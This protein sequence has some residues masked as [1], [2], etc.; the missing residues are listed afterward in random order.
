MADIVRKIIIKLGGSIITKKESSP[1]KANMPALYR[2][3]REIKKVWNPKEDRLI[4][5]HGAGCFGHIPAHE[6]GLTDSQYHERKKKG[7]LIIYQNMLQLNGFVC[8][9]FWKYE[10][11]VVSFPP[12]VCC[13][14]DNK[15]LSEISG[16][17]I[18]KMAEM[19]L[20]P[21]LYGDVVE[22]DTTGLDIV[23]GDQLVK[24]LGSLW[25]PNLVALGT[26]VDGVFDTDPR[27]NKQAKWIPEI[28]ADNFEKV[29]PMLS[30][31][32]YIDVTGGMS[33]K[34]KQLWDLAQ[35]G[36]Y[37]CIFNANRHGELSQILQNKKTRATWIL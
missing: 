4:V 28:N 5:I 17:R 19:G 20:I 25:K 30:G 3:A 7:A 35:A 22:D 34:I 9:A 32:S 2:L 36:T 15:V 37:S 16:Q 31:S 1:P 13:Q 23:S 27:H 10:I 26:D 14:M 8:K 18:I 6:Y 21:I 29:F 11:P 33:G 12:H 24:C